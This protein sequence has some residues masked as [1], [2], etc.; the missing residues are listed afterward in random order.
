VPANDVVQARREAFKPFQGGKAGEQIHDPIGR[1]WAVG[2]LD[3]TTID[4][5]MLRDI[6]RR[7][8]DLNKAV[9]HRTQMAVANSDQAPRG[10]G[11]GTDKDPIGERYMALDQLARDSGSKQRL[12]MRKLVLAENPDENPLWLDRLVN[13]R[14]QAEAA[15]EVGGRGTSGPWIVPYDRDC[16]ILEQAKQALVAMV[17]GR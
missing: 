11:D 3:G 2:L 17:E 10:T 7:Y 6:G 1:A 8:A 9:F 15:F 5:A 4:S 16:M 14:R 12:A 13:A